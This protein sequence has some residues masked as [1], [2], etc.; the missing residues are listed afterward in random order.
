MLSDGRAS[1]ATRNRPNPN[2]NQIFNLTSVGN[3]AYYGGF[4]GLAK[5]FSAEFQFTASYTLG[6]AFN[7]NDAVGDNGSNVINSRNFRRDWAFSSSD[8]RHRFVLQGVWQPHV[9]LSGLA[10]QAVNGWTL[11]PELMYTSAFPYTALAGSDL[12]GDGVNNDY[13]LYSSRNSYRGPGF[14]EVNLRLSRVF[15]LYR[16]RVSLEIIG[17][18][19]NLLNTTNAACTTGGCSGAINA[20]YGPTLAATPNA[21]FGQ[22]VSAFNSRQIQLGARLR[23]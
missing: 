6:W 16:E 18:A 14:Q 7:Q 10:G 15:P 1:F 11:A 13:S 3:S 9:G 12:N 23:F 17:E 19:E 20:T 4:V 5:R 22:I 2:F 8:Q 21:G